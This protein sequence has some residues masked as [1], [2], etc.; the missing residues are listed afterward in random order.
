MD[1]GVWAAQLEKKSWDRAAGTGQPG[2]DS[3]DKTAGTR[4][5]K[6]DSRDRKAGTGKTG[7]DKWDRKVRKTDGIVKPGWKQRLN[8]QNMT[9]RTGQLRQDNRDGTTTGVE[10]DIWDSTSS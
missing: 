3:Q 4:Q 5:P 10:R 6:Q 9:T 1:E 8:I 2:Q 7:Q